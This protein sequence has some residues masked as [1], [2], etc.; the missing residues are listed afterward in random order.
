MRM[1]TTGIQG[2]DAHFGGGVPTGSLILCVSEP[3]NA[4]YLFCEQFAAGGLAANETV[5]YYDL[6]R[7]KAEVVDRLR[8]LLPKQEVLRNLQYFDCYSVRLR[9]LN[10]AMLKKIGIENHAVKV[11]EDVVARLLHHPKD[12]PFRVVIESVTEA[13]QAY[14]LEPTVT[15]LK[16]LA[17]LVKS[18]DGVAL[19]MLVKGIAEPTVETRLRHLA[20]GVIEF[21]ME[22]QGFGLYSYLSVVKMR[23]VQDAARLLLYKETDKGLWLESTRRVF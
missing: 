8:S 11:N 20:D 10:P 17:G 14:G 19:V 12:Q 15:A 5:Y 1:V 9:E 6:E 22:R 7:P 2:L 23:G 4:P 16:T 13:I 21:G 3:S 18:L